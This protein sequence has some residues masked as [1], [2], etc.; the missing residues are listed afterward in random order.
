MEIGAYQARTQFS[1][2]LERVEKGESIAIT[3]HGR[4]VAMLGPPPGGPDRTS[5]DAVSG[6]L[7]LRQGRRLGDDL[8]VRDLVDAGRI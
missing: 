3:R 4:V 8:T 1:A 5:D 7:A 6:I 2:L